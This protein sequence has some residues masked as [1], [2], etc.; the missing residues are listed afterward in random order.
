[1]KKQ[2]IFLV[3]YSLAMGQHLSAQDPSADS[4]FYSRAISAA[5][6]QYMKNIGANSYLY[7]GVAYDRYWNGII[8]HP[9]FMNEQ[10]QQ[11]S[12]YYDG[13]FYE[14]VLLMYDIA[15]DQLVSKNFSKEVNISLLSSKIRYFTI[16]K[17]NFTRIMADSTNLSSLVTGFYEILYKGKIIVLE[18]HEKRIEHSFRPEDNITKFTVHNDMYVFKDGKYHLITDESGLQ[19]LF[20]EKRADIRMFLNRREINFKKDPEGTVMKVVIYYEQLKK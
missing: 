1:M 10:F 11:G 14:D 6:S 13:S 12:I 2:V 18:R 5:R 4:A 7:N 15:H 17:N 19:S 9:F 3:V 16:G 20:K 8:G